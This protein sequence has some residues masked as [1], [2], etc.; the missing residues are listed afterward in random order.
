MSE[1]KIFNVI[2]VKRIQFDDFGKIIEIEFYEG[3]GLT[4]V[5][6]A[7]EQYR[8]SDTPRGR[9]EA[10]RLTKNADGLYWSPPPKQNASS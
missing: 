10:I 8:V 2:S 1:S 5:M 7:I 3:A 9:D 6:E 4:N